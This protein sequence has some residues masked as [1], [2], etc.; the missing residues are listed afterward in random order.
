MRKTAVQNRKETITG[1]EDQQEDGR[2]EKG[3]GKNQPKQNMTIECGNL[4]LCTLI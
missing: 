2:R 3:G 1:E 4:V